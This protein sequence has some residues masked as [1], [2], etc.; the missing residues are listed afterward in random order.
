M[1]KVQSL[2]I[3]LIIIFAGGCNFADKFKTAA[4]TNANVSAAT[5]APM[6]SASP[7]VSPSATPNNDKTLL[8]RNLL[9]FGAGTNVVAMSSESH[10][11]TNT[12]VKLID[13]S[14][15]GEGW[16]TDDGQV[17]N[18]SVTLEFSARTTLSTIVFDTHYLG[19]DKNAPKDVRVEISD[20][21]ATDGFQKILETTLKDYDE[22]SDTEQGVDNQMFP[23]TQKIAGRFLRLTVINN[24]GSAKNIFTKEMRGYG[25]QEALATQMNVSGTYQ[26]WGGAIVHLKQEGAAVIGCNEQNDNTYEGTMNGRVFNFQAKLADGKP[27]GNGFYNFS[28]DN[29]KINYMIYPYGKDSFAEDST[30]AKKSDKIGNCKHL[31]DLD[32]SGKDVVKD[33]LEK[34]LNESGRAV[35]Y[36]IN[37]DFNSD[38]IR[39]ESKPTL[40]KVVAI[41]KEKADW[42]FNVEG[43]TDNIGGEAFNQN[44]SDKRAASVVKYLTDAGI[45]ASRLSSKGFGLSKP[46]A[47]NDS[48]AGRAQNR[49][50]ELVKQ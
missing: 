7:T 30:A 43:H 50:V 48:E 46:V 9:A 32:G 25:E 12:A 16:K 37:F 2:A 3:I 5:P 1:M 38:V 29:Q 11:S 36:G 8:G 31:P 33:S 40:E 14:G 21:S 6:I 47:P 26:T 10:T 19:S 23:V 49:R 41:L 15:Y 24:F 20:V 39:P 42:K 27:N 17:A 4:N 22:K 45:D 18:Q 44:L 35:L 28:S 34:T 13:E